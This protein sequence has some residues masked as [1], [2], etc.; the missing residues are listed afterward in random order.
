MDNKVLFNSILPK[1]EGLNPDVSAFIEDHGG[2]VLREKLRTVYCMLEEENE[3]MNLTSLHGESS[4]LLH[5]FDS[6]MLARVVAYLCDSGSLPASPQVCDVGC[7]GGFPSLPLAAAL[8]DIRLTSVDSTAKKLG[9]VAGCA[10]QTKVLLNTLPARA[11]ELPDKGYRCRFAAVTARAV[12]KLSVLSE[13][14][15]PLTAVGGYFLPMKTDES[16]LADAAGALKKL[17]G[18]CEDTVRYSLFSETERFS[19]VI[20]VIKKAFDAPEYPRKYAK[21]LKNPL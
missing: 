12:A 19:R 4:V 7:G 8:P 18:V 13:L 3:K 17:G 6:L 1:L 21:I 5:L 10:A 16:E 11:E 14:C 2:D 9:F 15:L 20:F